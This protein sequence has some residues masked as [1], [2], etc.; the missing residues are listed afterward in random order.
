[1]TDG[2]VMSPPTPKPRT[3]SRTYR[4]G[5]KLDYVDGIRELT[6]SC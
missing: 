5:V 6:G 4:R 1:M 2:P 3:E